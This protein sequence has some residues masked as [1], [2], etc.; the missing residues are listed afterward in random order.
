[1]SKTFDRYT[2]MLFLAIGAMFVIES[3]KLSQSAYGSEIGPNIFPMSL[4]I[5]LIL[6]SIRLVYETFRYIDVKK[7]NVKLDYK[8]FGI[9]LVAAILYAALLE[10]LGY[11]ITTFLF[12]L[13]GFQ[14]MEKGK[15]WVSML[16]AASFST[17]VYYLFVVV[18]QGS[19]PAFP[20]WISSS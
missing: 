14:T 15:W 10:P 16:I 20:S 3:L 1:M 11:V 4:G 7:N 18:L 9:I 5:A 13:I 6:L 2:G 12:L 17:G 19:L 8:R